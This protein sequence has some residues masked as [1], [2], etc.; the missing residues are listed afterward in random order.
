LS[1]SG[2]LDAAQA[3]GTHPSALAGRPTEAA[4]LR[5]LWLLILA[6]T[7]LRLL[8]AAALGLGIDESYVVAAGRTLRLG[9]FDHPP[10]VWWLSSLA[11]R[12]AGSAA[13]VIVRLPFILLFALSTWLIYRLAARLFSPRAG[14][15]AAI[16]LNLSPLFGVAF[17]TFVLPDGPLDACL[18]AAAL[19]LSLALEASSGA[20][21]WW[22]LAGFALGLA[23]FSKYS[24]ILVLAGAFLYLCTSP[25]HRNWLGRPAP[26]L[27]VLIAFLVFSPVLLWNFDHHWISF[28]Y[29]G[30]RAGRFAFHPLAPFI[31]FGGEALFLLPWIWVPLIL[32]GI[33][34][35]RSGPGD[36][37][38]WL[39]LCL[40][41]PAILLFSII[42]LWS[43][44]RVLFHWAAPGYLMLFPLLGD[45]I[46]RRLAAGDRTIR[47]WLL[48]TAGFVLLGATLVGADARFNLLAPFVSPGH[49]PALQIFDWGSL[50]P[51]LA[52][53]HLLD[54]PGLVIGTVRWS[55]A[56]KIDYALG[57]APPVVVL[58]ADPHEYGLIHPL[59]RY[60]GHDVL[61]IAPNVTPARIAA[62]YGKLFSRIETLPPLRIAHD[63]VPASTAPVYLGHGLK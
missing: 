29:Q 48:F 25:R 18:L 4:S 53:R 57:G 47:P 16:T 6:G 46:D 44:G 27:A 39:L 3:R 42:A 21:F 35:L 9:Y 2:S 1:H 28:A 34:A 58:G 10:A 7:A 49:D 60:C 5:A 32:S 26:W 14:L 15:W 8:F 20:L 13:P 40:G 59:A 38:R 56:A 36:W 55:D 12:L 33:G 30:G 11:A 45:A 24:A 41:L 61:I 17:G 51:E 52:K 23:L 54:R 22:L 62:D 19:F 50:R 31:V 37:Q 43:R 63:G